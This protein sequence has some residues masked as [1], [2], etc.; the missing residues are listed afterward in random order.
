MEGPHG[1]P[2]S[3][4]VSGKRMTLEALKRIQRE[5]EAVHVL[6][7]REQGKCESLGD[8]SHRAFQLK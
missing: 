1:A 2:P 4:T 7:L 6:R 8:S 3:E 5:I